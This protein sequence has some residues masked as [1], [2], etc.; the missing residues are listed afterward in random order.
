MIMN[1]RK[2]QLI[3]LFV[4]FS[5]L[6]ISAQQFDWKTG[7]VGFFD[8]REGDN[9]YAYA[10]TMFGCRISAEAGVSIDERN[11]FGAGIDYMYEFG[12]KGNLIAPDIILYFSGSYKKF[13]Y[14][15]GAFPRFGKLAM[16]QALLKDSLNY[17]RPN[18]EGIYLEYN[19]SGF[20]HNLWV[21]WTARKSQTVREAFSVGLSGSFNKGLFVYQHHFLINH[22]A[23]TAPYIPGTHLRDNAGYTVM[24][25]INLSSLTGLDTLVVT[26]G[27]LGSADYL[28]DV[29]GFHFPIGWMG[30]FEARYKGFGLHGLLYSG[31]EQDIFTGDRSFTSDFYTRADAYYMI[32][33]KLIDSRLQISFHHLV[34]D[35]EFSAQIVVRV[36]IGNMFGQKRDRLKI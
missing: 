36:H 18:L 22:L 12:S 27:I 15:M 35:N 29:Y 7:Y 1:L 32:S 23:Y 28:R 3:A 6:D 13:T 34:L 4:V 25:G 26:T 8:D 24:A 11:R 17:Y 5:A 21:D 10:Q 31:D 20:R 19:T 16:P 2:C 9:L 33:N 30:E 14:S